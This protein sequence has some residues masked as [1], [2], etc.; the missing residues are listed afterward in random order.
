MYVLHLIILIGGWSSRLAE[1]FNIN[2]FYVHG[3]AEMRNALSGVGS[4]QES[5]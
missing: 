3:P 1:W 2:S 5:G 4:G